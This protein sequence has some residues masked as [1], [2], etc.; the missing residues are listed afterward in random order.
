MSIEHDERVGLH[1]DWIHMAKVIIWGLRSELHS[2]KFIHN[3][4]F[5]NFRNLGYE[6]LWVDDRQN[7]R[8]LVKPG[9][10]VVSVDV[11]SKNLPI[12]KGARYILHNISAAELGISEKYIQLQ[13]HTNSSA[14]VNVGLPYISWDCST[15][16]LFQPWGVPTAPR[17]WREAS[18]ARSN[19]EYWTGSIWNNEQNQGNS[20]FMAR[21]IEVLRKRNIEFVQKGTPTRF[22]PN[23]ISE[24]K[25]I[26]L[27]SRSAIGSA[28]VGN[29]Q[30]NNEYIPCRLFKNIASGAI[31]SS[32]ADFSLLFG[33]DGGIFNSNPEELVDEILAISLKKKQR[34]G[35]DAQNRIL[36]Y[37]YASAISRI[38]N[39]IN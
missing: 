21:Y 15:K 24:L 17:H 26:K 14:G 13:V 29:W 25:S 37:T 7:H 34:M 32:N 35:K 10:L 4:F 18:T 5:L 36:P 6:T 1:H 9:D 11:A 19:K 23:G 28:V 3:G 22:H 12:V 8:E 20:D 30:K 33:K 39:Y 38:L 31:P 27:V 2:H 16:T